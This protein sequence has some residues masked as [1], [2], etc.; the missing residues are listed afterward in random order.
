MDFFATDWL[1]ASHDFQHW[2]TVGRDWLMQFSRTTSFPA[3]QCCL[4][5]LLFLNVPLG[6]VF[7]NLPIRLRAPVALA[8]GWLQ[9]YMLLGGRQVALL[10][11]V[12]LVAYVLTCVTPVRPAVVAALS[13]LAL[14]CAFIRLM[15]WHYGSYNMGVEGVLMIFVV[16]A[17]SCAY[18]VEDGRKASKGEPLAAKP[19][20]AAERTKRATAPPS[21]VEY[22]AFQFFYAGVLA[23]PMVTVRTFLSFVHGEDDFAKPVPLNV[24]TAKAL[25]T[26]VLTC[27]ITAATPF[28]VP[29]NYIIEPAFLELSLPARWAYMHVAVSLHRVKYFF[30]WYLA[31]TAM[32]SSGFGVRIVDGT[33]QYDRCK[34][35]RLLAIESATQI[36]DITR[37][38]NC[39]VNDWLKNYVFDRCG[40]S[41][42]SSCSDR[43]WATIVTR[44]TSA[45][46]HGFYPGYYMFFGASVLLDSLC[47]VM[48]KHVRPRV[49]PGAS[50]HL[51]NA[52]MYATMMGGINF[53]GLAFLFFDG[54][55]AWQAWS[56]GRYWALV[57]YPV[58]IVLIPKLFPVP[59]SLPALVPAPNGRA[60]TPTL[61]PVR[62]KQD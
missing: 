39:S 62:K 19:H 23:G 14:S 29:L 6:L 21:L 30:A 36:A 3:D 33:V 54:A 4:T 22:L 46:W 13:M 20:I 45:F 11:A 59:R 7:R 18:D 16:K 31:E 17:T 55:Q 52:F 25:A 41:P 35:G 28:L 44:M 58:L 38:W 2:P 50:Q 26:A 1:R 57:V 27:A 47:G 8:L 24:A 5:V 40:A 56:N 43:T 51:Y 60:A 12:N 37:N 42:T 9:L 32:I 10:N 53:F 49:T 61:S 15:V 48:K 34:N